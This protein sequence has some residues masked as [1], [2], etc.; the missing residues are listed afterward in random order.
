MLF[1]YSKRWGALVRLE[2]RSQ[3]LVYYF[4]P[5]ALTFFWT[6]GDLFTLLDDDDVNNSYRSGRISYVLVTFYHLIILSY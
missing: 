5:G 4:L 3:L 1:E 6:Q 2:N